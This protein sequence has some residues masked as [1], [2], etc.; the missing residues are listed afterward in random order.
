MGPNC[1]RALSLREMIKRRMTGMKMI[2]KVYRPPNTEE[3]L[4]LALSV[5]HLILVTT[6]CVGTMTITIIC[7]RELRPRDLSDWIL[8]TQLARNE[9][10]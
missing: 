10:E 2:T 6:L 5:I 9:P 7:I 8:I 4:F 3:A 1:Q